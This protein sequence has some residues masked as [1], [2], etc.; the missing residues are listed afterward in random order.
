MWEDLEDFIY[1]TFFSSIFI[2]IIIINLVLLCDYLHAFTHIPKLINGALKINA[3]ASSENDIN[4]FAHLLVY[5]SCFF[6]Y[7]SNEPDLSSTQSSRLDS[8]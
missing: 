7:S 3:T 2:I 5:Q 4:I 1:L 8:T 6:F